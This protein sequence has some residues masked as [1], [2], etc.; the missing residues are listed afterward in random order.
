MRCSMSRCGWC[1]PVDQVDLSLGWYIV[2]TVTVLWCSYITVG[3][4]VTAYSDGVWAYPN[5]A[6]W[7]RFMG[8][9]KDGAR[10]VVGRGVA[11]PPKSPTSGPGQS[12]PTAAS[13]AASE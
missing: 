7:M 2:T 13:A 12:S 6:F 3:L 4:G 11:V 9:V 1:V 10:V 5:R 8:Y